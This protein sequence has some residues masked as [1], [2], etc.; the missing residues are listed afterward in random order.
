MVLQVGRSFTPLDAVALAAKAVFQTDL[1]R[2]AK[3]IVHWLDTH[4]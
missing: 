2:A 1:R 4:S 3:Q